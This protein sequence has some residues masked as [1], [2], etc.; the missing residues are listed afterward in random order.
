MRCLFLFIFLLTATG[1]CY[2]ADT[3]SVYFPLGKAELTPATKH[4]LDSMIR[5]HVLKPGEP[6]SIIGYCDY[7]GGKKQNDSLSYE[8]AQNVMVY[9]IARDFSIR[10][11][12]LCIGKGKIERPGE[13]SNEGYAAD[14][15]VAIVKKGPEPLKPLLK[16]KP[17]P[18]THALQEMA[19]MSVDQVVSL[20]RIF[21]E[22]GTHVLIPGSVPQ[23]DTLYHILNDNPKIRIRIEG[24]I[25]CLLSD[26]SGSP[27]VINGKQGSE[28][29]YDVYEGTTSNMLSFARAHAVCDFLTAKGIDKK[30]ITYAG[31]GMTR[32]DATKE[33]SEEA[34]QHNRRVDIRI[35]GK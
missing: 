9:F 33:N 25:C 30:R 12:E 27:V 18:E 31:L 29:Q 1:Y 17:K 14:R 23:L 3:L 7:L 5:K 22:P 19:K 34:Q 24:H 10:D 4:S 11:I 2:A 6:F 20:N 28:A 32:E 8:R 26:P 35:M 21:F 13:S 15:R 16:T